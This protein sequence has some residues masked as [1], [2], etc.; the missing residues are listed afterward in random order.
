MEVV[1]GVFILFMMS[2]T[3]PISFQYQ[4]LLGKTSGMFPP[5]PAQ[6]K[7]ALIS[8]TIIAF[9]GTWVAGPASLTF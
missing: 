4:I 2:I 7:E 1:H 9:R 3:W 5:A 8:P 6:G